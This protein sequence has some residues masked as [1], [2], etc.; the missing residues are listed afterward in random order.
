MIQCWTETLLK[1]CCLLPLAALLFLS[2]VPS[3]TEVVQSISDCA[4]FLLEHTPPDVPGVLKEGKILDQ[5]RYKVIC[6][7][8]S[9]V[10][11]FVTLYDT[12]NRIPVFSANKYRGDGGKR[13]PPIWKIE[14][15]LED[16]RSNKNM[17]PVSKKKT[18]NNQAGD[19]DYKD[20][21]VYDR[22]HLFP[23][24]YGATENDKKATFTLTNIVPQENS[25]NQGSWQRMESCVKCVLDK[26]CINNNNITEGFLVIGAQPGNN[27][28][29]DR[30]NIPSML[31]SAF[32]CYSHSE[33]KWLASAH[34]GENIKDSSKY[35]QT[36]TLAELHN[37]LS[38]PSST[39][40]VFPGTQCPLSTT[41]T[42][43]Y[44]KLNK[45]CQCP[46]LISTISVP[47]TITAT[48]PVLTSAPLTTASAP[49]ST[50]ADLLSTTFTSL[51]TTSVPPSTTPSTSGPPT[52]TSDPF[53]TTS[54]PPSTTS[55]PFTTTSASSTSDPFTTTSGLLSTTSFTI[56]TTSVSSSTT[57]A[58]LTTTS[59][60]FTTTAGTPT[61][62]PFTTTSGLPSTTS[63]PP[64]YYVCPSYNHIWPSYHYSW[65][66]YISPCY[67]HIFPSQYNICPSHN[68]NWPRYYDNQYSLNYCYYHS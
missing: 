55:D 2:I 37:K 44:P 17:V 3:V 11:T 66:L 57:S 15:Q 31:W 4:E 39:F 48:S 21:T 49:P 67:Y 60:V 34:W 7:T 68:Y 13:P 25:F 16:I 32:C 50:T 1:M 20:Q 64:K 63:G 41:V 12:K 45:T 10:R 22:G 33:N 59:A 62:D 6:Q 53:T 43:F 27:K 38:I 14:P 58:P 8:L 36:K 46:P 47:P 24:S 42:Q 40:D 29:K 35:L 26:Y 5:N 54:V 19:I 30:V 9:N 56:S 61:S 28:L 23:C 18:Y 65:N 51:S 52:T